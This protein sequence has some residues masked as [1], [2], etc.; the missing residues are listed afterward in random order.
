MIERKVYKPEEKMKIV[1]EG[2]NG[3]IQV[4]ELCSKNGIGAARFYA[5][6]DKMVE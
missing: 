5:W 3:T 4:T 6:K 1:M 2:L